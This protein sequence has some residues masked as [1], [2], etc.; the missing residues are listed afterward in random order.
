MPILFCPYCANMLILSRMDTGGNRVECRTCPYQHAIDKPYF[1]RKVFPKVEKED[2]FGGP[3]TWANAQKQK[4]QCSSPECNGGEAA[5]FQVQIRSADE[6]MTTF[7]RC[8]TCGK[9][10]REN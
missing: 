9:N 7:Y 6:P 8:L 3:D 2:L 4:V 1:S 5:F 10:W